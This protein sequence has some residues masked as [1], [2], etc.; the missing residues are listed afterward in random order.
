MQGSGD[1]SPRIAGIVFGGRSSLR[2]S[3]AGEAIQKSPFRIATG[4]MYRNASAPWLILSRAGL[5]CFAASRLAMTDVDLAC[6][7]PAA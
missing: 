5:V 1:A 4:A 7:L 3:A 6:R 2:G